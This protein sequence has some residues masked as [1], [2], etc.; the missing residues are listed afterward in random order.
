MNLACVC[1]GMRFGR[2]QPLS[3]AS[4]PM[5]PTK[6]A[7]PRASTT[8]S[9]RSSASG[10][11]PWRVTRMHVT[12]LDNSSGFID[13]FW[14]GVLL[15]EQKSAGR[16][17]EEARVQAWNLLRRLAGTGPTAVSAA[18]RLPKPSSSSTATSGSGGAL[19][20]RRPDLSMSRSSGSSSGYSAG[21]SPRSGPGQHLRLPN[22][23]HV[24]TMAY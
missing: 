10:G 3:R 4:G 14:P 2:G 24:C 12:R 8:S 5:Q 23:S 6:R 20:P 9:S 18:L 16:D 22:W 21:P 13:L 17:L 19:H 1:R 7:R 15:V 11:G